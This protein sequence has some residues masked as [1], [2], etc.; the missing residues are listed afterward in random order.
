MSE[1]IKNEHFNFSL[2]NSSNINLKAVE[3]IEKYLPEIL[4]KTKFF[5]RKNSQSSL[6]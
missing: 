4:E 3:K 2:S 6:T 5:D 1:L